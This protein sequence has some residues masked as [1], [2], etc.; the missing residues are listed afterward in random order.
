MEVV[1]TLAPVDWRNGYPA[2]IRCLSADGL[3]AAVLASSGVAPE[4]LLVVGP[5]SSRLVW[6]GQAT[7]GTIGPRRAY[8][9]GGENGRT[10][11]AV[12]LTS[13]AERAIA[14]LP[15][16]TGPLTPSPGGRY[17]AGV[18]VDWSNFTDPQPARVVLVD[19]KT[20]A[21]RTAPLGGP[22]VTAKPLWLR[23]DRLVVVP[24]GGELDRVRV[25]DTSLRERGEGEV[26]FAHDAVLLR[27]R[28]IGLVAPFLVAAPSPT[29]AFEELARLPSPVAYVLQAVTASP[30]AGN[31]PPVRPR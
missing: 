14:R 16:F 19:R 8:L 31:G 29:G 3:E 28:L 6:R 1:A 17:L 26:L 11:V 22:Y 2:A 9:C 13:G 7:E 15:R 12:S 30:V 25:F 21:V 10:A 18:A 24:R 23:R 5:S 27:G 4:R 20:G